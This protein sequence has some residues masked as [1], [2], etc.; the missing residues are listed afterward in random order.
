MKPPQCA[1]VL[2][3]IDGMK[4]RNESEPGCSDAGSFEKWRRE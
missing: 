2:S 3:A 1:V 4:C